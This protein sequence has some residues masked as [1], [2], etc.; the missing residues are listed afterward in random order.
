MRKFTKFTAIAVIALMLTVTAFA[1]GP[2]KTPSPEL[3]PAQAAYTQ[4]TNTAL[5]FTVDLDGAEFQSL[6]RGGTAVP[7]SGYTLSATELKL[8]PAYLDTLS[9]GEHTFTFKT[10]GGNLSFTVTVTAAPATGDGYYQF[11][12]DEMIIAKG[13]VSYVP[14]TEAVYGK[15]G[16]YKEVVQGWNGQIDARMTT[17]MGE[18]AAWP[19]AP[20]ARQGLIDLG[21]EYTAITFALSPGAQI[22]VY[23]CLPLNDYMLSGE[24]GGVVL[25]T[26]KEVEG[27]T[28]EGSLT[29]NAN[30]NDYLSDPN[31]E[32][33]VFVYADGEELSVGD[34]IVSGVWYTVVWQLQLD[35]EAGI[36]MQDSY[37][38]VCLTNG[39]SKDVYVANVRYY[40]DNSFKVDYSSIQPSPSL[41]PSNAQYTVGSGTDLE[42]ALDL[43]GAAFNSV[44]KASVALAEGNYSL[45]GTE[46]KLKAAYLDTLEAG[47]HSFVIK[48]SAGNLSLA[49]E[50]IVVVPQPAVTPGQGAYT[51]ES[52]TDVVFALDLDGAAFEAIE[53][54]GTAIAESAYTLEGTVLTIKSSYLETLEDGDYIFAVKTDAGDVDFTIKITAA[55]YV[56]VPELTPDAATYNLFSGYDLSLGLDL[57]GATLES[58]TLDDVAVPAE[59]YAVETQ[60][61]KLLASYLDTLAAGEYEFS[62]VTSA[63]SVPFT[64]TV[65][66]LDDYYSFGADEMIKIDTNAATYAAEDDEVYG[67]T[68][69]YAFTSSGWNGQVDAK[70]T[71]HRGSSAPFATAEAAR[72]NAKNVG[73]KYT[74]LTIALSDDALIGIYV[75]MPNGDSGGIILKAGSQISY[76]IRV[77]E[78]YKSKF[79]VYADGNEITT[80]TLQ[81]GV[82]YTV[83]CELMIDTSQAAQGENS[84]FDVGMTNGNGK[85]VYVSEVRYYTNDTFKTDYV[86]EE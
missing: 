59:N 82:W 63:G 15:T 81:A 74:A 72:K 7:A 58:I 27:V 54:G 5:S 66:L 38:N 34:E 35:P 57:D 3:T 24:I 17:H 8:L 78:E 22:G 62:M 65:V 86:T 75:T 79:K 31:A 2:A 55:A 39:N 29:N 48:T 9:A 84:F 16:V 30:L 23:T 12:A 61:L 40:T 83:V 26:A 36:F 46:F 56:P 20:E 45:S 49:V 32:Q 80:E 85:K 41:T 64:V 18:K 28:V 69:V 76:N 37:V 11:G 44:E 13:V 77:T 6:E 4:G 50:I 68:G 42:F 53:Q 73:Y 51:L 52:G 43:D 19:N 33:R 70:Q 21:Y 1:C 10:D 67:K 14:V 71:T 60:S 47:S 25:A